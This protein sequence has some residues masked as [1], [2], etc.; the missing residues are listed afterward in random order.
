MSLSV[1]QQYAQT[2]NNILALLS[3]YRVVIPGIQRH[4]VQGAKNRKAES[5]RQQFVKEILD[6]ISDNK[7][8]NLHFIYGPINTEGEDSFVPVDGQQRLTTLW[9]IARYAA[10]RCE[11]VTRVKILELLSR[12]SYEDRI[13]ATRFCHTLT[14]S[15]SHWDLNVDPIVDI[16]KQSWFLDYWKEDETVSSM[17]RMLSTIH[18]KW[19]E[20]SEDLTG[21]QVIE[22]LGRQISFILKIDSFGDDIYMKMNARGLQLTQWENFKSKFTESLGENKS[23]WEKEIEELSNTFF[24]RSGDKHELPD[25]S[26]FALFAR[27]MV[28][29]DNLQSMNSIKQLSGFTHE[30]W[31]QIELP[32]VPYSDFT[33]IFKRHET[34]TIKVAASVVRLIKIALD[35]EN[36][37]KMVPYYGDRTLFET[38]FHP[39]NYND[40]DFSLCCYEYFDK[41]NDV[42]NDDFMQATRLMWNIL[43]NVSRQDKSEYNRIAIV[44]RF[45]SLN[46]PSLYSVDAIKVFSKEEPGQVFEEAEKSWKENDINQEKPNDWDEAILGEWEN[47]RKAIE[48]AE[49][50]A[51]FHGSIRFLYRDEN[52]TTTWDKYA[53]KLINCL[54]LF[55]DDGLKKKH[56]A[57]ANRVLISHCKNWEMIRRIPVFDTRKESWKR[58]LLTKGLSS[59]VNNLLISPFKISSNNDKIISTLVDEHLWSDLIKEINGY[60][61]EWKAG[62]PALWLNRYLDY[63]LKLWRNNREDILDEFS[64]D[65]RIIFERSEEQRFL[66]INGV[67]YYYAVPVFFRYKYKDNEYRFAWQTWGWIDMYDDNQKLYDLYYPKYEKGFNIEINKDKNETS[68]YKVGIEYFIIKL[69]ECINS[70][71]KFIYE[72]ESNSSNLSQ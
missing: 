18:K 70:Y 40:L 67:N 45:I 34:I 50:R 16:L 23:T 52:G 48:Y 68:Q 47:W 62:S 8:L 59:C 5:I 72:I 58:I 2:P 29:K 14:L 12:F 6:T 15:G 46:N 37:S 63:T 27:V 51:F 20:Y 55:D 35:I 31:H 43:E 26:F 28:Y 64:N 32:F 1:I 21:E 49:E 3:R 36:Y 57:F 39:V 69:E 44:K 7:S 24:V 33:D 9:L 54:E 13:N 19:K 61:I 22:G 56:K 30:T 38:L 66:T 10:E 71:E 4:Y 11:P 65:Y 25:N 60:E 41:Y 42:K 53:T 17:I